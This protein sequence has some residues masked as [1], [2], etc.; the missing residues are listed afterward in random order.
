MAP[1]VLV[2]PCV[3][4]QLAKS[5]PVAEM[6]VGLHRSCRRWAVSQTLSQA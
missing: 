1:L 5:M 6:A 3:E 2:M 4:I